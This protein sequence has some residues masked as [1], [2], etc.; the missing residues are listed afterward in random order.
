MRKQTQTDHLAQDHTDEFQ[1]QDFNLGGLTPK[2][3]GGR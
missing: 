2:L 1:S 3:M